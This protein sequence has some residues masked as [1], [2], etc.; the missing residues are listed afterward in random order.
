MREVKEMNKTNWTPIAVVGIAILVVLLVGIG[1]LVP[2]WGW[3]GM[4]GGWGMMG[5]GMMGTW[6]SG[7]G[8][9]GWLFALIGL[10]I[11]LSFLALLALGIVWLVRRTSVS[12]NV[13][14]DSTTA[15]TT[16]GGKTCPSCGRA[17]QDDWQ[18]CPYCGQE[19]V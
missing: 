1:F 3:G 2:G 4:M 11:P 12:Q 19:L 8:W 14:S 10:L 5:P 16:T 17:V 18:L 6:G 9:L 7:W 13:S 15:T